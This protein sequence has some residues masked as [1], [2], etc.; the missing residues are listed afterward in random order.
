MTVQPASKRLL[1]YIPARSAA[2]CAGAGSEI[3]AGATTLR[4]DEVL[5]GLLRWY[6]GPACGTAHREAVVHERLQT[7]AWDRG[8]ERLRGA[9]ADLLP[10]GCRRRWSRGPDLW[11]RFRR[12]AGSQRDRL[13]PVS[14]A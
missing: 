8:R 11:R 4:H 2:K 12:R 9:A 6:V 10:R 7:L 14:R 5:G 3:I 1:T 13:L